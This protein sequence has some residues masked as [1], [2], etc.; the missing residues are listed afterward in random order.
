MRIWQ[1][2]GSWCVFVSRCWGICGVSCWYSSACVVFA[3]KPVI[4]RRACVLPQQDWLVLCWM[5]ADG[6][7]TGACE[8]Q[9]W[10]LWLRSMQ[11]QLSKG[12]CLSKKKKICGEGKKREEGGSINLFKCLRLFCVFFPF[13]AHW[14]LD[15]AM[16]EILVGWCPVGCLSVLDYVTKKMFKYNT[17]SNGI[18]SR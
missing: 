8:P 1:P 2:V 4:P 10:R 5:R 7:F 17:D 9:L 6:A 15:D 16:P 18:K 13:A 12:H 3:T 14:F 11:M